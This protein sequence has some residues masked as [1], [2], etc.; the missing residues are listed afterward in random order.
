MFLAAD[1]DASWKPIRGDVFGRSSWRRSRVRPRA[2]WVSWLGNASVSLGR[3][4]EVCT[5]VSSQTRLC[6]LSALEI[7]AFSETPVL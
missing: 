5:F 4:C 6:C 7:G 1:W 3:R 2:G